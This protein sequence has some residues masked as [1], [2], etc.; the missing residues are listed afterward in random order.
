MN[1]YY[2]NIEAALG[3]YARGLHLVP[4]QVA[5]RLGMGRSTFYNKLR[6]KSSWTIDNL[7]RISRLT[8]ASYED[9]VADRQ[10]VRYPY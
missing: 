6:G 10:A 7:C 9:L 8:G 1:Y 3:D 2:P 5:D 4:S